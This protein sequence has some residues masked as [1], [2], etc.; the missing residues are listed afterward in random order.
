MADK[1]HSLLFY[2]KAG[3]HL[4]EEARQMLARLGHRY[5]M[6]VTE[7]DITSDEALFQRYRDTIPVVVVDG[8]LTL[9]GHIDG[10]EL[11]GWLEG[12]TT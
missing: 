7:V 4:C 1:P 2:T 9:G 8:R 11:S 5:L 6:T 3:C 12:C 10:A